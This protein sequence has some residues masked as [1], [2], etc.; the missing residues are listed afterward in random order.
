M[1]KQNKQLIYSLLLMSVFLTF[2]SSCKKDS[3]N[4]NNT[5][6]TFTDARD[7]NVYKTVKIGNQVWMAENLKY[8]PSVFGPSEGS[9]TAPYYYVYYSYSGNSVN[10]AKVL[11]FYNT[12][13]VLY[14]WTAAMAGSAS[15]SANP[16]RVQGVCPTGWHM[17]SDTE[18]TT[19]STYLGDEEV[20]G[21]LKETF[22][23]HW[24]SPNT[25][26]TNEIGFTA[27]PGGCRNYNGSFYGIGGY[28]YW[29]CAAENDATYAWDRSMSFNN[30]TIYR[31]YDRKEIGFS[32]RCVRD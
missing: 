29:W 20:G 14:N 2:A 10:D 15:S 6:N 13:G 32:V 24:V 17:P 21:K 16:S 28:G 18:W 8:L 19:L 11:S 3:D 1:K 12:Y 26:A 31:S 25:G 30:S 27:L 4:G 5:S 23:T 9:T 7:G 22:T